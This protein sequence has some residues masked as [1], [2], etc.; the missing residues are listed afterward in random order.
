MISFKAL[1]PR[2]SA[3]GSN[4]AEVVLGLSF[5]TFGGGGGDS[6]LAAGEAAGDAA[7][8]AEGK[9]KGP[10]ARETEAEAAMAVMSPI[11]EV[12]AMVL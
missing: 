4:P 2:S 11:A 10:S 3:S 6:S 1:A 9:V 8:E 7:G 12:L 5:R